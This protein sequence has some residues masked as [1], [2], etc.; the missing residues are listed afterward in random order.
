MSAAADVDF[1]G[2]SNTMSLI[3]DFLCCADPTRLFARLIGTFRGVSPVRVAL[4]LQQALRKTS[5]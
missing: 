4:L 1:A 5:Y 3:F 2:N